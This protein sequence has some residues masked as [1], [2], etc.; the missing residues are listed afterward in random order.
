LICA[1][2]SL[3]LLLLIPGYLIIRASRGGAPPSKRIS[4]RAWLQA[5]VASIVVSSWTGL[6]LLECTL[7][8]L[9][10]LCL[11]LCLFSLILYLIFRPPLRGVRPAGRPAAAAWPLAIILLAFG[12]ACLLAGSSEHLF[13]GWD[14][15]EYVNMGALFAEWGRIIYHDAFFASVPKADR[16]LF[17]DG[18]RRY[19]GFNLLSLQDATVSPKFMHLYPL[20]LAVAMKLSGVRAALS[21]N[22][23]FSLASLALCYRVALT[24]GGRGAAFASAAFMGANVLQLWFGRAQCAEPLAQLFF[25][26]CVSFWILW[27]RGGSPV[28]APLSAACAGMMVL[29]KIDTIIILLPL[30]AT[31]F[32]CERRRGEGLFC[33]VLL[34]ALAHAAVHLLWWDRPYAFALLANIPS[35]LRGKGAVAGFA[36]LIPAAWGLARARERGITLA[37]IPP[38]PRL[39]GGAAAL[40]LIALL[41]FVRPAVS[42][43]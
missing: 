11:A 29:T 8:S 25:L 17:T 18:G 9:R 39:W 23:L 43:S 34:A 3:P 42:S 32:L 35:G 26:G 16:A 37:A 13:G 27:R 1:L 20:W 10:N 30:A 41:Y 7:F 21:L 2:I 38:A 28:H 6:L 33:L 4:R 5:L 15:G 31:L 36:A 40:A 12:L 24:L 22:V 14:S 19:M